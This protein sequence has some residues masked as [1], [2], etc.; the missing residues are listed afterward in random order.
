MKSSIFYVE[1]ITL[2]A[3]EMK[4]EHDGHN[5][6]IPDVGAPSLSRWKQM[7]DTPWHASHAA[8]CSRP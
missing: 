1:V 6:L 4:L 7:T 2:E 3:R 5:A 8:A